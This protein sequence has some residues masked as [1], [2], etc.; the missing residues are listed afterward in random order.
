V[1]NLRAQILS[2]LGT[3]PTA[4][5]FRYD[6]N[7]SNSINSTDQ[8]QL[9]S[10]LT[11][12]LGTGLASFTAATAPTASSPTIGSPTSANVTA[13]GAR[14]GATVTSDGGEPVLERGVVL[15]AGDSGTPV[16][17]DPVAITLLSVGGSGLFTV[18]VT[19]L[20]ASMNYRFRAFVKTSLGIVYSDVATFTTAGVG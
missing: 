20:S 12:A 8:T 3:A 1:T 9:R 5:T 4:T 10:V 16:V 17:T 14:L 2:A 18:D 19:G 13:T 6:L 7:G 11:T 15:L